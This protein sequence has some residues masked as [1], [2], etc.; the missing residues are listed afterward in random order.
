MELCE[1]KSLAATIAPKL[2]MLCSPAGLAGVK[3]DFEKTNGRLSAT[4]E[5]VFSVYKGGADTIYVDGI[6]R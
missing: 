6:G 5:D 4:A 2:R 1:K 3:V